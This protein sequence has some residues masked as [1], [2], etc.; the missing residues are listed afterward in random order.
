MPRGRELAA[1]VLAQLRQD[2][3][4]PAHRGRAAQI[5]GAKNAAH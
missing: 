1:T 3:H 5:R 4:D 2:G